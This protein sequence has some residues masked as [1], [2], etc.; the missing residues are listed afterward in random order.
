MTCQPVLQ[1]GQHKCV[2][3][4]LR[5]RFQNNTCPEEERFSMSVLGACVVKHGFV[6]KCTRDKCGSISLAPCAQNPTRGMGRE[7]AL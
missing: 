2:V 6:C 1:D 3:S 7:R 4:D 5:A